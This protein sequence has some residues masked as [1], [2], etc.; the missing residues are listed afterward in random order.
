MTRKGIFAVV[1]VL[2]AGVALATP[3]ITRVIALFA[4]G[5][6]ATPGIAF[7]SDT[8]TGIYRIGANDMGFAAGGVVQA[9]IGATGLVIGSGGTAIALRK[10]V[11][12]S[13]QFPSTAAGYC[14]NSTAIALTGATVG[15]QCSVM[16]NQGAD[17]GAAIDPA[18]DVRCFV[19]A[20][21]VVTLQFCAR[22][23]D[24]G[25]LALADAGYTACITK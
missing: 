5:V 11:T 24:A 20:A 10:C 15:N 22:T 1:A 19:S 9:D 21:D 3:T 25:P 7:A 8:D 4:D 23:A 14:A 13:Q 17:G 18:A 6:V 16:G 2:I 12:A